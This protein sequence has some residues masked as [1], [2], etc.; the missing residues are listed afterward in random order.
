MHPMTTMANCVK[1]WCFLTEA[2]PGPI[3][4]PCLLFSIIYVVSWRH[5]KLS[6][7]YIKIKFPS[8]S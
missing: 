6:I 7:K 8:K 2:N 5:L 1:P 3:V 4:N